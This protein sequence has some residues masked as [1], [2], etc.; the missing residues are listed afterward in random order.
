MKKMSTSRYMIAVPRYHCICGI[1]FPNA[2]QSTL[3]PVSLENWTLNGGTRRN[4]GPIRSLFAWHTKNEIL[5]GVVYI[6]TKSHVH[7]KPTRIFKI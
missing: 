4:A 2:V 7:F 1:G 3:V 5:L 6:T